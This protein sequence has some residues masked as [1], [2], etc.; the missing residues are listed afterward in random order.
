MTK[1][2][3]I[4]KLRD[5]GY[6]Y[7]QIKKE[8]GCSKGT[9]AYH[10]GPGQKIKS[11]VRQTERRTKARQYI[12][13]YKTEHNVCADCKESYPYWILEF[14]H[15]RDKDFT[16]GKQGR[17]KDIET[18]KN[19]IAKCEIVCANCH[20]NRTFTRALTRGQN[21]DKEQIE[22]TWGETKCTNLKTKKTRRR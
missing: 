19:E 9:I 20:K 14:D 1:K 11:D 4:L 17:E 7:D 6:S 21:I 8:V 13:K 10:C 22:N 16:I 5:E 3:Q 2:E 15:I 18:L 12:Q